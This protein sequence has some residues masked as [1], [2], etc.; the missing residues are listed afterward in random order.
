MLVV[1][2]STWQHRY[3]YYF[4]YFRIYNQVLFPETVLE[5]S[6]QFQRYHA[7]HRGASITIHTPIRFFTTQH[8]TTGFHSWIGT[9]N[10]S[11]GVFFTKRH[12]ERKPFNFRAPYSNLSI[13][14]QCQCWLE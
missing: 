14:F 12:F 3:N 9:S 1:R 5:F 8:G 6:K 7:T 13:N 4:Y 10:D 11:S 2:S